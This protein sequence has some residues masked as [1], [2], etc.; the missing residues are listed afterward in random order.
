MVCGN[1]DGFHGTRIECGGSVTGPAVIADTRAPGDGV[2]GNVVCR[3]CGCAA[4]VVVVVTGPSYSPS[5]VAGGGNSVEFSIIQRA[6][7]QA[8]HRGSCRVGGGG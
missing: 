7:P 1:Y 5:V 3:Y 2:F 4:S 8:G 6:V